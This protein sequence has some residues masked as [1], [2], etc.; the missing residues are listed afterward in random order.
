MESVRPNPQPSVGEYAHRRW[1]RVLPCLPIVLLVA[2]AFCQLILVFTV[3]L[4][5]WLGGGF[6]M[7]ST[8]DDG[9]NR[10]L[11][12]FVT[13]AEG[14]EQEQEIPETLTDLAHRVRVLPSPWR[15]Q[16]FAKTLV[17]EYSN[18][19]RQ[20]SR[21]RVEVWKTMFE[22]RSLTPHTRKLREFVL[23]VNRKSE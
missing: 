12:V 9:V 17:R 2:I 6:G 16:E 15:L 11:R 1:E 4:S 19:G 3:D 14:K 7:F 10:H 22:P 13:R 23:A 20:F 21:L 18:E 8:M 5:P